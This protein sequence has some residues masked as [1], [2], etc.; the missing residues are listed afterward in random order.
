MKVAIASDHA[1]LE[2]KSLVIKTIEELNIEIIDLGPNSSDSVDYPDYGKLVGEGVSNGTY[3]KG[4]LICGTGLGMS[5]VANKYTNVLAALCTNEF[6]ARMAREHNN[7]N[8]LVLGAR[9]LG[10]D[11]AKAIVTAFF[12]TP[13]SN[14]D[15][16]NRRIN[17]IKELDNQ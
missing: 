3:E 14:E 9:V 12:K 6:M 2:M 11:L 16:H 15:R 5:Y 10:D 7:A 8:V 4:I 13:F 1:G 17:K